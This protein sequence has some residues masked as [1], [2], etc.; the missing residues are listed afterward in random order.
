[1]TFSGRLWTVAA[2]LACLG[3]RSQV[4]LFLPPLAVSVVLPRLGTGVGVSSPS[5]K[6]RCPFFPSL[7]SYTT[8]V[9]H[10]Q[11]VEGLLLVWLHTGALQKCCWISALDITHS[12][13]LGEARA[14]KPLKICLF[15]TKQRPAVSSLSLLVSTGSYLCAETPAKPPPWCMCRPRITSHNR[16]AKIKKPDNDICES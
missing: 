11:Q 16:S 2:L 1:M 13:S 6:S 15:L 7:C 14:K 4:V 10:L 9:T 8:D 12:V 3:L 5:C